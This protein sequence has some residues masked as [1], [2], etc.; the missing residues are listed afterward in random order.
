MVIQKPSYF[1][2]SSNFQPQI[3][4][5]Y[6]GIASSVI[7]LNSLRLPSGEVPSQAGIEISK[8]A[9][10]GGGTLEY[11][12]YSQLTL[13]GMKT[14]RVKDRDVIELKSRN[15]KGQ[16]NPGLTLKQ[17]QG[18][19][20]SYGAAVEVQLFVPV[21]AVHPPNHAVGV[22]LERVAELAARHV[23]EGADGGGR[24]LFV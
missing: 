17:L 24:S 18:I 5:L 13:L 20:E 2:L 12:S 7:V 1:E 23:L 8:P 3:N 6:C 15:T 9:A 11:P 19:L 21:V 22:D 4:P 16:Y 10:L 14:N